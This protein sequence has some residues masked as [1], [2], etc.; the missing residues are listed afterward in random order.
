MPIGFVDPI[1]I[2]IR[3]A[4]LAKRKERSETKLYFT[5]IWFHETSK[6]SQTVHKFHL[7]S[8]FPKPNNNMKMETLPGILL[9]ENVMQTES[10]TDNSIRVDFQ[11][12]KSSGFEFYY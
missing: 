10:E 3:N 4:G 2:R 9:E 8:C 5:N 11:V 6:I 1:R 7:V 12:P